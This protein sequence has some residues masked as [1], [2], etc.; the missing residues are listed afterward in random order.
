MIYK[1]QDGRRTT[2]P[3]HA[4]EEIGPTDMI[5]TL[6]S[7]PKD[8]G[9]VPVRIFFQIDLNMHTYIQHG[10]CPVGDG[11]LIAPHRSRARA[12]TYMTH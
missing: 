3:H 11:V 9:M 1:H 5:K 6:L 4:K 12:S 2:I 10:L 8:G 7:D